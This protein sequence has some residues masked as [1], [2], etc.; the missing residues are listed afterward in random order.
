MMV[1]DNDAVFPL[2]SG[3][4]RT[5]L[6]TWWVVTV[7]AQQEHRLL[8]VVLGVLATDIDLPDPVDIPSL[9]VVKSHVVLV[10]AGI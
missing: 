2:V 9:V 5:D 6:R 7:I 4:H 1:N 3:L 10:P 8:I